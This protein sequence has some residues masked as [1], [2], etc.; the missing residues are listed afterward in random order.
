[1]TGIF[2]RTNYVATLLVLGLAAWIMLASQAPI[3]QASP[4]SEK[5]AQALVVREQIDEI[6]RQIELAAEDYNAANEEYQELVR[7]T[8]DSE[9]ELDDVEQR[10][11]AIQDRLQD[12]AVTM[13][14][15][16]PTGLFE[17]LLGVS[18]F[19]ELAVTWDLLVTISDGDARTVAALKEARA[20]LRE[21]REVLQKQRDQAGELVAQME[22][23]KLAIESQLRER[24]SA[25]GGLESEI[26]ALEREDEERE[27]A[28]RQAAAEARQQA[29]QTSAGDWPSPSGTGRSEVVE[30]AMRYLGTPY[31]WGAEGPDAFDCSGFTRFVY[32]QV[33]IELPRVSRSQISAGDRVSRAELLP[34]DLVFFG[35][36]IHHVGIYI[37][38]GDM[39]HSP[40]TGDVVKISPLSTYDCYVGATRP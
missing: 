29:S 21:R 25:L 31:R 14:R 5:R 6:D 33:G 3:A 38:G 16:G 9:A 26:A 10:V 15:D 32:R 27:R 23:K 24:E 39:V 40:R 37:G 30:I 36:P 2:R 11:T 4:L 7:Q 34:G 28:R 1:M 13:Y 19:E 35:T 18:S 20:D 8:R 12:R 17:V 22:T